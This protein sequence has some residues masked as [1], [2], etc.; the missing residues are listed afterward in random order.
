[1]QQRGFAT[2]LH[3]HGGGY[4]LPVTLNAATHHVEILA[5]YAPQA[6]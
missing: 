4:N 1:M 6:T 5:T 2:Y 3:Y